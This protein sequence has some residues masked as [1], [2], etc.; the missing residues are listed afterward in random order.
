MRPAKHSHKR[1][2]AFIVLTALLVVTVGEGGRVA[3]AEHP[4]A[5]TDFPS[6]Q[7]VLRTA[8]ERAPEV[9]AG[10]GALEAANA[11]MT[12]ARLSPFT[13]P[14][15]EVFADRRASASRVGPGTILQSNLWIPVEI[16]GQRDRR[17][18]ESEALSTWKRTELQ[19]ATALST[20]RALAA[21]GSVVIAAERIR[22]LTA[23]LAA[24]KD[25]ATYYE[26]RFQHGDATVRDAKLA[27]VEVARNSVAL[28]QARADLTRALVGLAT[29]L[30]APSIP[31]PREGTPLPTKPPWPR[32][33]SWEQ[34]AVRAPLVVAAEREA[35]YFDR[36]EH[37]E[38]VEAHSPFNLIVSAA[39]D[40]VGAARFGG[41]LAW[42]LPTFRRNQGERA[43]ARAE[44]R[45]ALEQ[46]QIDE[47]RTYATLRGLA[48]ERRQVEEAV[49]DLRERGEP[50]AEAA[51]E[52]ALGLHRAGKG[53][54]LHVLTARRD[55]ALMK[56]GGLS[57]VLREWTLAAEFVT[58]TGEMP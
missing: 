42:A 1:L 13:N 25:E 54:L 52:A 49:V 31:A 3:A 24:S 35:G 32:V 22:V 39:R 58:L 34:L 30:G 18:A 2:A 48:E 40:E 9:I 36:L 4:I 33:T 6:L 19:A 46:R 8:S 16:S 14:Y 50:A 5:P 47:V 27:A 45:R 37:R 57:L 11:T 26:G 21:Y 43:R 7:W 10:R 28:Q 51:L 44:Q 12:G 29:L 23:V 55:L 20:G 56:V 38:G 53:D 17:V 15:V 41:G